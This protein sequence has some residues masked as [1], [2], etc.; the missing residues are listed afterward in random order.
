MQNPIFYDPSGKRKKAS[1]IGVLALI[2]VAV[3]L[4]VG[5]FVS[6]LIVPVPEG[7]DLHMEYPRYQAWKIKY[8]RASP[9]H[10]PLT[11]RGGHNNVNQF[12]AGFYVPWDDASRTSLEKHINN[13]DM[14]LPV[15]ASVT[16]PN[17]SYVYRP[18]DKF[19]QLMLNAQHKPTNFLVVQNIA[20]QRWDPQGTA[21]LL[22]SPVERAKLI[23]E[24][25]GSL[26]A[27]HFDGVT[28]DF[29]TFDIM[30][31]SALQNYLT[32]IKEAHATLM[33]DGIMV[34]LTV[35][36]DSEAWNLKAFAAAADRLFLMIYDE[37]SLADPPGPIAG[38]AW[39]ND[40]L[41][42][43]LK[44]VPAAKAVVCIGNYGYDWY[45]DKT[46]RQVAIPLSVEDVWRFAHESDAQVQ[47]DP[48]SGTPYFLYEE[49]G[50]KHEVWFLDAVTAWNQLKTIDDTSVSGVALWYMGHEDPAIWQAFRKFQTNDL[51]DLTR[52]SGVGD[53]DVEG[54]GEVLHI[55]ATPTDGKRT[56]AFDKNN[57]AQGEQYQTLP[58]G[59]VV[60]RTTTP[61]NK[62][63]LT[64]D[65]GP[66]GRWTPQILKILTKHNVNATFFVIGEKAIDHPE[67]LRQ[68]VREGDEL[69]N[70]SY[71]HPD[72]SKIPEWQIRLELNTTQRVVEAYTGRSMR[73]VR[74]PYFGDAE[75]T[76]D[77]EL[78]PALIGQRLG[79]TNVGL[80]VDSEDWQKPGVPAIIK[81]VIDGV[82]AGTAS[83][84]SPDCQKEVGNCHSGQIILMHD[85]GGIRT[86][87]IAALPTIIETLQKEGYQFV[88][89]GN[90]LNLPKDQ[91]MPTLKGDELL[92]VRFDV[93]LFLFLAS[94]NGLLKWLFI[95]AIFLGITRALLLAAL[96]TYA[97][98]TDHMAPPDGDQAEFVQATAVSVV[99]PAYN[100]AKVI[101]ASVRRVLAST[102]VTLEIVVVDDGSK[103]GTSDVITAAFA[104]EPRV[105]LITQANAG[106]AAAVNNGIAAAK[107][108]III[109]L[110]A[111][112]QFEAETI[113]R[114]VRW[115]VRPEIGAVAGNAKV[116]NRFNFV[117]K[118][119]GVEYV[120]SQNLER[121]ALA[122][123]G[124]MMVVP[125]AVGAWRRAALAEVGG[126][127]EN[128][129]AE[130]QDLTIAIQRKGWE[131]AYDQEAVAW[132]ESPE[133]FGSLMKQRFRWAFGTL[134]CLWKHQKIV[135]TRKPKGLALI[136]V[137][138]AWIFQIGFSVISPLIDFALVVN[139]IGTIVRVYQHGWAETDSDLTRML[140]YWVAFLLID[141]ICG[142]IAYWLEPREK[143][144]PVFWLLSQRFVYRQIM[145][146]VVIKALA[147]AWRGKLVGWGKLERSGRLDSKAKAGT[148]VTAE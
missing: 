123:F 127:P 24:V 133:S 80:H 43:A 65:D 25:E 81:N 18:D 134:Q 33:K 13:I 40:R 62:I 8:N 105:H 1:F 57:V 126:Y 66:D 141:A 39:F 122:M 75:P 26:R 37:H 121:S 115:F 44:Q 116:G 124:A 36:V 59:Y 111:D 51:P 89:V 85:S 144:Y 108:E 21:Q 94:M 106:K 31:P 47:F 79:Y 20:N 6:I 46:G 83:V 114:L 11:V 97:E 73:L 53:T 110:D 52:L 140:I 109:A 95:I 2:G 113:S 104:N 14:V 34:N 128:T 5:L 27:G 45:A 61:G 28:F 101:E 76:T 71:T 98:Y 100:E 93:G 48:V 58:T 92:Q 32:F 118:W 50:V 35:P 49:D 132:T 16:G 38:Q 125:G 102:G 91:V 67:L 147:A 135:Q 4:A 56:V 131:V 68:M 139:V 120:T 86:E 23:S 96:A 72:M 19:N 137:P 99:I 143:S 145:Y 29:E 9:R 130:D 10:V 90:L 63:A 117:T 112:T 64:F 70:H 7:L 12:T 77:D 78:V 42:W 107:G 88:T 55:D 103:D 15:L 74:P 136:G 148:G 3:L 69:G 129:L 82:H 146:Y 60:R 22:A 30:P 142:A 84:N 119:Q 54:N 138:Q 17:H 41:N 87:T